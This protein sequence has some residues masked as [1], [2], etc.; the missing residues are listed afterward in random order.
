MAVEAIEGERVVLSC[1]CIE[2]LMVMRE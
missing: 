1:R 2:V